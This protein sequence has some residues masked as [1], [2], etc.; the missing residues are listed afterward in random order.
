MQPP[1]VFKL[2]VVALHNKNQ[3]FVLNEYSRLVVYFLTLGQYL[4]LLWQ[5]KGQFSGKPT[6]FQ[7][8]RDNSDAAMADIVMKPVPSCSVGNWHHFYI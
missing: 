5:L 1:G 7:L 8:Y 4:T 6:F 2:S 3:S